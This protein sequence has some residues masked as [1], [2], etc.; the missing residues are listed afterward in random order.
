MNLFFIFILGVAVG[1]ATVWFFIG[2]KIKEV[3]RELKRTE[4]GIGEEQTLLRSCELRAGKEESIVSGI[5]E[6]NRR[7]QEIKEE[8]KRKI[9]GELKK[10]SKIKT[11]EVADLLEV[12]RATAFRYLEELEQ[13]GKIEQ[14]GV[15]GRGRGIQTQIN[16]SIN[17]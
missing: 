2:R 17:A 5:A 15:T 11:N 16:A 12:S 13:E 14:I 8:R 9:L 1:A 6:F 10:R 7:I 3:E 4:K